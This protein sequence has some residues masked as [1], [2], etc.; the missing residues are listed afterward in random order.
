MGYS[1]ATDCGKRSGGGRAV[2]LLFEECGLVVQQARTVV[3]GLETAFVNETTGNYSSGNCSDS[4]LGQ[5]SGSPKTS[6]ETDYNDTI[7]AHGKTK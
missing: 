1:K 5:S 2:G 3:G 6:Q 7:I 4:P